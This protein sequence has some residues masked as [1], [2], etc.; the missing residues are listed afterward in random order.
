MTHL[1]ANTCFAN[2]KSNTVLE[3]LRILLA[4]SPCMPIAALPERLEPEVPKRPAERRAGILVPARPRF[5]SAPPRAALRRFPSPAALE[6]AF[7]ENFANFWR[8]RSRLDQNRF[9]Q[10]NTSTSMRFSAVVK[11]KKIRTRVYRFKVNI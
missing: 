5:R 11:I 8:A 6:N 7:F 9:L 3:I 10:V 4:A 1:F 2:V